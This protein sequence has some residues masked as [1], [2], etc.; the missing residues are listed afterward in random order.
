M[1]AMSVI[2]SNSLTQQLLHPLFLW[3]GQEPHTERGPASDPQLPGSHLMSFFWLSL[4]ASER[5]CSIS[6]SSSLALP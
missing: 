5:V 1:L 3:H 6:F 2:S 4:A